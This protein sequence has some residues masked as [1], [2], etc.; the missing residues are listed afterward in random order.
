M[1]VVTEAKPSLP[2]YITQR[3]KTMTLTEKVGQLFMVGFPQKMINSDLTDLIQNYKVG[4]FILFRRNIESIE[5]IKSL[6]QDLYRMSFLA[7]RLPPLIAVDQEGGA[8]S[9]LPISPRPPNFLALGQTLDPKLAA[10]YGLEI[11]KFLSSVGFNMNLAPVLDVVDV[12]QPS[13]IGVR[14]I[15]SD[16]QVVSELGY[17]YSK[18]LLAGNVIPTAKHF[19]GTGSAQTDPHLTVYKSTKTK[20]ELFQRD[21][22]PFLSFMKLNQHAAI[23]MSHFSYPALDPQAEPASFS[24][25]IMSRLLRDQLGFNGLIITD[26]L[27]MEGS[28][29]VLPVHEASLKSLLAGADV[30]MM[31]WSLKEQKKSI[32]H[33]QNYLKKNP[34]HLEI[35]DQKVARILIAKSY[36]NKNRRRAL[37]VD[38]SR[39]GVLTTPRYQTIEENIFKMNLSRGIKLNDMAISRQPS[40]AIDTESCLVSNSLD[41]IESFR[42]AAHHKVKFLHLKSS[43]KKEFYKGLQKNHCPKIVYV[44]TTNR[45]RNLG[46]LLGKSV[47]KN[48]ILV[49]TGSPLLDFSN[50]SYSKVIQLSFKFENLGKKLSENYNEVLGLSSGYVLN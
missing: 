14:S 16:P 39:N 35:F 13:F 29:S 49:N 20:D 36:V 31:T 42:K 12:T 25:A 3:L 23:M 46:Q 2:P 18:G 32:L 30:I 19:P 24:Q 41:V 28:K 44:P 11:G 47:R 17:A 9:R 43:T 8:V 21:L 37:S 6:N 33:V 4:S 10:Q 27:Q 48:I 15:G 38:L 34:Q 22:V 50:S 7:N 5:Q 1:S 26:D 45:Y 40:S